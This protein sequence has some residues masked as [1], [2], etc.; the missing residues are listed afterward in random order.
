MFYF[1]GTGNSKYIAEL[2]CG[3]MNAGCCSIEENIDFTKLIEAEETIGFCYPVYYSRVPR[4]MREFAARHMET[5]KDKTLI[6]L[7]TQQILSGDGARAFAGLFPRDHAKIAYAEHFFMPSNIWPI[8]TNERKILSSA[9]K[10]E[11]KIQ[12]VCRD[13]KA[14][15]IKKR[16]FNTLS[17]ALGLIQAPLMQPLEKRSNN[18]IRITGDCIQCRL[19]VSAC[20]M[21]NLVAESEGITH[22][23]NCT[24]CYRCINRCPQKA[25]TVALHYKVKKQYKGLPAYMF[26]GAR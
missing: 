4:I 3:N 15:R 13:I 17:R 26:G 1:S 6:I 21:N 16:G 2:F 12:T 8:T 18:S 24:M 25:I 9:E 5:L 14:E 19:C 20:P 11:R 23:H 7:C 22:Q 10:A